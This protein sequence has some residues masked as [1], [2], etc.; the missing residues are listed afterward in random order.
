MVTSGEPGD[1]QV[2][3]PPQWVVW[4]LTRIAALLLMKTV[5]EPFCAVH[6][7]MPQQTAWMPMSSWRSAGSLLMNTSLE[8]MIAGPSGGCGHAGQQ[9]ASEFALARSDTLIAAG[10]STSSYSVGL[11]LVDVDLRALDRDGARRGELALGRRV[12]L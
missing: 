3:V 12:E 11:R 5:D 6:M 4:S 1:W 9:C 7:F 10:I 8:P 2:P